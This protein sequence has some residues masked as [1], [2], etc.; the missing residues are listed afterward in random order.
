VGGALVL[1]GAGDGSIEGNIFAQS[2]CGVDGSSL[3]S[4]VRNNAFFDVADPHCGSN[5]DYVGENG[6]IEADPLFVDLAAANFRL[7]AGSPCV[8][9]GPDGAAYLDVDGTRNDMG[10][11]GGPFTQAGGW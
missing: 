9:A 7:S 5:S 11:Y 10:V 2:A 6:N 3:G 4:V 8:D 1:D